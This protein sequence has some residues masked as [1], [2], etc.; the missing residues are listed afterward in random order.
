MIT[1]DQKNQYM[2]Q[3]IKLSLKEQE[4]RNLGW[5]VLF[6]KYDLGK[7]LSKKMWCKMA[8]TKNILDYIF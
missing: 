6:L 7:G 5:K 4:H 2:C 1:K 3:I 8:D